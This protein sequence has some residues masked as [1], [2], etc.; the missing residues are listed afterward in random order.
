MA[1]LLPD[2]FLYHALCQ[3]ATLAA[4]APVSMSFYAQA[5]L[6]ILPNTYIL[7]SLLPFIVSHGK[8]WRCAAGL[9][10]SA[11]IAKSL[12]LQSEARLGFWDFVTGFSRSS[13]TTGGDYWLGFALDPDNHATTNVLVYRGM[14]A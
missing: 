3:P 10:F 4:V 9:K 13:S 14:G 11:A 5:V 1:F 2:H 7:L 6:A 12:E 8:P